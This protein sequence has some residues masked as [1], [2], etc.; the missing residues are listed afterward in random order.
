MGHGPD[1]VR[2]A[3]GQTAL[4]DGARH[5][6]DRSAQIA[7]EDFH[8]RAVFVVDAIEKDGDLGRLGRA[9]LGTIGPALELPPF[10]K[11]VAGWPSRR[12]DRSSGPRR[13]NDLG[14]VFLGRRAGENALGDLLNLASELCKPGI[15]QGS[16]R[17]S[18]SRA[19]SA[20][21]SR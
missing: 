21:R 13:R 11:D 8:G 4:L 19:P 16:P 6:R 18:S 5:A 12:L 1:I 2:L 7:R 9:G 3:D 10:G 14:Q 20:S 15:T 17:F